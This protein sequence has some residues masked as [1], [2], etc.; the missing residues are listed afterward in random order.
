M[1]MLRVLKTT[2]PLT[3][4]LLLMMLTLS[5]APVTADSHEDEVAEARAEALAAGV[6][7]AEIT[8]AISQ[9][10]LST[11]EIVQILEGLKEAAEGDDVDSDMDDDDD[12]GDD[13]GDSADSDDDD[14][15]DDDG[16]DGGDDDG[17]G[18]DGDG[19]DDD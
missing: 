1:R 14:G 18:G 5:L 7:Q 15:G 13:D 19:G 8:A 6:T 9:E 4:L 2:V 17:D 12:D 3:G 11:H 16:D 10:G